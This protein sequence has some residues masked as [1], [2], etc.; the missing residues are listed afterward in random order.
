MCNEESHLFAKPSLPKMF[1]SFAAF[2]ILIAPFPSLSLLIASIFMAVSA[3]Y[4]AHSFHRHPALFFI[5]PFVFDHLIPTVT[6]RR[7]AP[8]RRSRW[9]TRTAKLA[10]WEKS[11]EQVRYSVDLLGLSIYFIDFSLLPS[12]EHFCVVSAKDTGNRYGKHHQS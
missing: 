6:L 11:E 1:A 5:Y 3:Q 7:Q 2:S 12:P 10:T 4:P 8:L 9:I